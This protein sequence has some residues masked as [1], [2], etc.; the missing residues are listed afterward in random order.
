MT[1][2]TMFSRY[3]V[4]VC[5]ISSTFWFFIFYLNGKQIIYTFALYKSKHELISSNDLLKRPYILFLFIIFCVQHVEDE[6]G[7]SNRIQSFFYNFA[8]C[9]SVKKFYFYSQLIKLQ[10]LQWWCLIFC[11]FCFFLG[12]LVL[13]FFFL[14]YICSC[15]E[16][17]RTEFMGWVR[18][19]FLHF[20]WLYVNRK[21]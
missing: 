21:N 2:S 13:R 7:A 12:G 16:C 4:H 1:W 8:R 14:F 20:E 9:C 6:L 10:L 5:L 11:F 18:V 15:V 3:R 19:F 17:R